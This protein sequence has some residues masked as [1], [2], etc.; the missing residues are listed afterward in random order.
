MREVSEEV[1]R[2]LLSRDRRQRRMESNFEKMT[3]ALKQ[4][5]KDIGITRVS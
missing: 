3:I 2:L 5:A 4:A 1:I